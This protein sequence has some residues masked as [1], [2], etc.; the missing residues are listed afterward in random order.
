MDILTRY[1]IVMLEED[2]VK[3]DKE[4][5]SIDTIFK[6]N[7]VFLI[8]FPFLRLKSLNNSL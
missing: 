4:H 3:A 2:L 7:S 8:T 1:Y 5:G 6:C